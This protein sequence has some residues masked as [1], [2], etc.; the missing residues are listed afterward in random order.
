[1]GWGK[2]KLRGWGSLISCKMGRW[3]WW[4]SLVTS[5]SPF[6]S[7]LVSL[8]TNP[9]HLPISILSSSQMCWDGCVRSRWVVVE[10]WVRESGETLVDLITFGL[11]RL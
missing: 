10:E 6:L 2:H 1:M 4:C 9:L 3:G 11:T 5:P 7:P 8:L